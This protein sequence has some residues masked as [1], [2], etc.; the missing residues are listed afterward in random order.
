MERLEKIETD[1]KR[2]DRQAAFEAERDARAKREAEKTEKRAAKRRKKKGGAGGAR[3]GGADE[4]GS[5]G[6]GGAKVDV[7]S[8][9]MRPA[10]PLPTE[11][12]E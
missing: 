10:P 4:S 2:D 8:I 3:A 7:A 9:K 12:R 11:P 5:D 1:A 6:G